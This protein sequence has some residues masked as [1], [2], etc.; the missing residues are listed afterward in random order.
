MNKL[1]AF[2][3][4]AAFFTAF[5]AA[6]DVLDLGDADFDG[7]LEDVETA[8]VM[9]Y[10]PWCGHCKKIKPEFERAASILK[11]NDPPVTLAKVDCTEAGKDTCGRF[12]VSGYP[13]IKIFRNGELSQDYN[14]PREVTGIVKYMKAQVGAASKACKSQSDV[15]TLLKKAEVVVV[16]YLKD[17]SDQ[18]VFSKVANAQRE[19]VAFGNFDGSEKYDGI[20]LHR[21]AHLQSKF[22]DAEVKYEGKMDKDTITQ[23]IKDNYH[24]LVG[25]RTV[26]NAKDFKQPIVVAYFDVDYV[27]NVKG[28]NY[29][30]NRVMKVA[31]NFDSLNFAVANE[32]DFMQEASEF[33]LDIATT[34][35]PLVAIKSGKGKFV[36]REEFDMTTFEAFLKE[37][38]AGTLDSYLKSEAVPED[39][40]GPVKVAVAKNF[41]ELVT[42]SKKDVLV[43]FYAPWCGHCKKLTPIFD[44]LGEKMAAEDVDIVKM[45]ATANDVPSG[46][47]VKGFPTLFWVPSDTKKP[48]SYNGGREVDNF[49]AFIAEKATNELKSLDRKGNAKKVEL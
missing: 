9:F 39:N 2:V 29:W 22:E 47:D 34:D 13:T 8:L 5:V 49:V 17:S 27:K 33:G 38:E 26:D 6:D 42:N 24:G 32:N 37:Y 10:A 18:D 20:V 43:E 48:E 44:E 4:F 36:M 12:D 7:T 31:K 21:P 14:G 16:S 40:D 45:D 46:Y 30:R 35:K 41:D 28:T 19:S 3:A 15:D 25:L 23:W 1:V 11:E